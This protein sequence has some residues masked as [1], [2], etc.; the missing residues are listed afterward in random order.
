MHIL[1]PTNVKY[2]NILLFISDAAPYMKKAGSTIQ[3]LYPNIIHLTCLA[4]ACHN[5][6]EEVRAYYKNVDQ[7]I[8]EMKKTF[9]KCPKRIAVLKEKCP[10]LPN[11]P[12]PIITRWGTWINA[13]KYYCTNFNELKSIIEEFEEESECVRAAKRLFKM[14]SIQSNLVYIVSNFGFLPDTITKLETRGVLLS[15]SVDIV[16]NIQIK[17]EECNGEIAKLILDKFN[18]VISKNKGWGNIKNINQVLIG[19]TTTDD[20][21]SSS[22]LNLDNYLSMKY[23]PITSVDVERSFSMYKNILTSNRNRFTEDNL[24]KYMVVN[25]FLIPT[26]LFCM[27]F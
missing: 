14:P 24:S 23:A 6:C 12:R 9:L 4:H 15:K 2:D 5:V 21:L 13:V 11:P 22:N 7:L 27:Q 8:S 17:L 20:D 10:E 19:E 26:S 25:F 1:W 16:N 18:K 3:T